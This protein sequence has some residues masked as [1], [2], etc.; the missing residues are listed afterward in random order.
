MNLTSNKYTVLIV[1]DTT[2]NLYLTASLLEDIY[3]V[4]VANN[5]NK[6]LRIATSSPY[7]DIILLDIMM[8]EMDGYEVCRQLKLNQATRG[9]PVIFL[10]A[11]TDGENEHEGLKLGAVDYITKPINPDILRVRVRTHL[12][13]YNQA[14]ILEQQVAERTADLE[15]NRRQIIIRLGRAAEFKDNET[16]N[17]VIRMSNYVRLIAQTAG[18]DEKFIELLYNASPMHDIGKIGIPD[19]ILQ[20]PGKLD[21]SEWEIMRRHPIIGAEIIGHHEDDLLQLA[22]T[23]ALAHHEKWDGTGYPYQLKAEEIPLAAR[24][25]AIADVFDALTSTRPYKEAWPIDL[26]VRTI[27]EGSGQYFDPEF[28]EPFKTAL[29]EILLIKEKYIDL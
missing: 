8:P 29:P 7:P 3:N 14:R 16:G 5:G 19:R 15:R 2:N 6:G 18:M 12:A 10:T 1:D 22:Y 21:A 27:E 13:L 20:K 25:V 28:I 11:I 17:H 23:V 9:I 4:K 26:A 24:I